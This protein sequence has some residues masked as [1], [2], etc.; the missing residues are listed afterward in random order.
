M[1]ND[2]ATYRCPQCNSTIRVLA[3]EYGDHPC[4]KCGWEPDDDEE[5]FDDD[6]YDCGCCRCCGCS[7]DDNEEEAELCE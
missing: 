1:T 4:P 7:C 6:T 3:D 5:D 2:T